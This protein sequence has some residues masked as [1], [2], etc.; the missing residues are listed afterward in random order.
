MLNVDLVKDRARWDAV[1]E[2]YDTEI[3]HVDRLLAAEIAAVLAPHLGSNGHLLEAG[4]GSGH[5][6]AV[7][8]EHGYQT[9]LLD[10]S[11]VALEAGRRTF[12]RY[13]LT[14]EFLEGNLFDMQALGLARFDCVW[15]SG[16]LEHYQEE[17]TV[18]ALREMAAC[19]RNYVMALVPNGQSVFYRAFRQFMRRHGEWEWG[20]ENL[21]E[22]LEPFFEQAGL[23]VL[24][25]TWV[26]G[27]YTEYFIRRMSQ[28]E[29]FSRFF[30]DLYDDN[31]IPPNQRYLLLTFGRIVT[32]QPGDFTATTRGQSTL[33]VMKRKLE[34]KN[35]MIAR[36]AESLT[37]QEKK[38]IQRERQLESQGGTREQLQV[39]IAELR[40]RLAV[41]EN[42]IQVLEN[43]I[44]PKESR[45]VELMQQLAVREHEIQELTVQLHPLASELK[46]LRENLA[47]TQ[48]ALAEQRNHYE[49]QLAEARATIA[50]LGQQRDQ[51]QNELA[52]ARHDLAEISRQRAELHDRLEE[53]RLALEDA[54]REAAAQGEGRAQAVAAVR[55]E[56]EDHLAE[57]GQLTSKQ[58]V[59]LARLRKEL[60]DLRKESNALLLEKRHG[61]DVIS[62]LIH[63][64]TYCQNKAWEQSTWVD[65]QLRSRGYVL[66]L[67]FEAVRRNKARALLTAVRWVVR[68]LLGRGFSYARAMGVEY[69]LHTIKGELQALSFYARDAEHQVSD[70]AIASPTSMAGGLLPSAQRPE[71]DLIVYSITN[72]DFRMQR[73]Q[74]I[75]SRLVQAGSRAFVMRDTTIGLEEEFPSDQTIDNHML[76]RPL[77]RDLWEVQPCTYHP[78]NIYKDNLADPRDMALLKRSLGLLRER[79]SIGDHVALVQLPFW[80]PLAFAL[81]GARVIYDCMDNHSDFS[82]N[83]PAMLQQEEHLLTS[84]DAVVVSSAYLDELTGSKP[85][86]KYVVRNACEFDYFSREPDSL[87]PLVRDS[88]QPVIGYYGA[89]SDWFDVDLVESVAR[90]RPDWRFILIGYTFGADIT[91]LQALPNVSF[92]GEIPYSRL[93]SFLYGFDVCLI[94][95]RLTE[96]IRAT[97]PV[98]IYEYSAAGKPTVATPIPEVVALGDLVRTAADARGFEQAIADALAETDKPARALRLRE[99]AQHNTWDARVEE[100]KRIIR[101]HA[102]PKVS[103]VILSYNN[104]RYTL[105]C[106]ES[107]L[108]QSSYP[109]FEVILIDNASPELEVREALGKLEDPRLRIVL[110]EENKGYA[111]GN[112]QGMA[113]ARGDI[114]I[115]LNNDTICPAD[116]IE[117]L[118]EPLRDNPRLGMV[119]PMTNSAGNEQMLDVFCAG[120]SS[121][122]TWLRDF[123]RV[124]RGR[125]HLTDRLGFFCV[126]LRRELY[127]QIGDLDEGFE[128]GY[129]EDDDYCLRAV[130]AGWQLAVIEDA[131][132]YHHGS[133]SF[134]SID[135]ERRRVLQERNRR[136]FEKKHQ[137]RWALPICEILYYGAEGPAHE[138][139]RPTAL[140]GPCTDWSGP[141]GRPQQIAAALVHAGFRVF[142]VTNN[143][144]HDRFLGIRMLCP[145]L[146]IVENRDQWLTD[147][148]P[149]PLDLF[150]S[151]GPRGDS[152]TTKVRAR[153]Y[154]MD[155]DAYPFRESWKWNPS[156]PAAL[157]VAAKADWITVSQDFLTGELLGVPHQRVHLLPNGVVAAHWSTNKPLTPP[158]EIREIL[159][160]QG[161][162]LIAILGV[163][164]D[165]S[166]NLNWLREVADARPEWSFLFILADES[167]GDDDEHDFF[168]LRNVHLL[169][170]KPVATLPDYLHFADVGLL[171]P[172]TLADNRIYP[173]A[174]LL[175]L[176][177]AGLPVVSGYPVH[178]PLFTGIVTHA[179]RPE[180]AVLA[181]RQAMGKAHLEPFSRR[182]AELVAAED[183]SVLI[184]SP[185]AAIE[186]VLKERRSRPA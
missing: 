9:S 179:P 6:S 146:Y 115:L 176:I 172:S 60:G 117:R 156:D 67:Y 41:K 23:E 126:A 55:R 112:N 109:N 32:R 170:W 152:I 16:V 182:C 134:N 151:F 145:F 5:L 98:K 72:W 132:V 50:T 31:I 33:A 75:V 56:L 57:L 10:F 62:K 103:I 140:I 118:V 39:Q 46:G 144:R 141:L 111:G 69:R 177:G 97:N 61:E 77:G 73:P 28:N 36:L 29:E 107:I 159:R 124:R 129:F 137:R 58:E 4:S 162:P 15:N 30:W 85:R 87:D 119:G 40:E 25:E 80:G 158:E 169:G 168:R 48:Q 131:F 130:A 70:L 153:S 164:N 108:T 38:I 113:M 63:S 45:L 44:Q 90:R 1:A 116:W 185:L 27:G 86:V 37:D 166:V 178:E 82:T 180:D 183:W 171:P 136:R 83:D 76:V 186:P 174:L 11:Q 22:S 127:E 106:L 121:Q 110:N 102:F 100:F 128:L 74:H 105:D 3:N 81:T 155:F 65:E 92:T 2:K 165:G 125:R 135:T 184:R 18:A 71:P 160:K 120:A 175:R 96:L 14:G 26:D 148:Q 21:H 78:L 64:L 122:H 138:P 12:A 150:I 79:F 94:P 101:R 84:A 163:L 52:I 13:G 17:G 53:T 181:I 49:E 93:T 66:G 24:A 59:Q 133:V 99:F 143:L 8:A 104:L 47:M 42:T 161:G 167:T 68:R 142:Y 35:W 114:I 147:I 19:S 154:L 88:E 43:E 20:E 34:A 123:Y 7:L 91:R 157:A 51:A 54:R 89:I 95:F 139:D 173:R 149:Q